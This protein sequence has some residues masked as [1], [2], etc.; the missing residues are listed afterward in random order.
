MSGIKG[1]TRGGKGYKRGK[2]NRVRPTRHEIHLDVEGGEGYYGIVTKLVGDNTVMVNLSDGTTGK[3]NIPGRMRKKQW[4][5]I[6]FK[7]LLSKDPENNLEV[8]KIIRENDKESKDV[9][10]MMQKSSHE[11]LFNKNDDDDDMFGDEI[12]NKPSK[13]KLKDRSVKRNQ[14]RDAEDH[15]TDPLLLQVHAETIKTEKSNPVEFSDDDSDKKDAFGNDIVS[16]SKGKGKEKPKGKGKKDTESES[17]TE[18]DSD[19]EI[20]A[21][22]KI[23]SDK[24]Q[25]E[26][27]DSEDVD[28]DDI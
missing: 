25:P 27:E 3:A 24:K 9:T 12:T 6:G 7:V 5:K 18:S 28:I 26:S 22:G 2:T 10:H 17:E 11:D 13:Q 16:E 14:D 1:N 19:S 20:D 4:I 23:Q 8:V 21:K 15:F